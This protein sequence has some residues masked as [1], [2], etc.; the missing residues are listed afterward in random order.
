VDYVTNKVNLTRYGTPSEDTAVQ[1]EVQS[2]LDS[3]RRMFGIIP[4]DALKTMDKM[5]IGVVADVTL[6]EVEAIFNHM[7]A[8]FVLCDTCD[9]PATRRGQKSKSDKLDASCEHACDTCKFSTGIKD[10]RL[11]EAAES[12]HRAKAMI[13]KLK[14]RR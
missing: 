4:I 13:Y 14:V 5:K 3:R 1:E 10:I 2:A 7:F 6:D 8:N 11:T 12:I 9:E